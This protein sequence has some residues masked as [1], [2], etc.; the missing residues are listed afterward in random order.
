[1]AKRL[2]VVSEMDY[3]LLQSFKKDG[4]TTKV[5]ELE[6]KKLSILDPKNKVPDDVRAILYNDASRRLQKQAKIDENTP[7]YVTPF[8]PEASLQHLPINYVAK[9]DGDMVAA[10]QSTG[11]KTESLNASSTAPVS[12]KTPTT[13]NPSKTTAMPERQKLLQSVTNKKAPEIL[14]LLESSGVTWNDK[15]EVLI[16]KKRV[17]GSNVK[18]ILSSLCNGK[19]LHETPG[20]HEVSSVLMKQEIPYKLIN[21]TTQELLRGDKFT[22][23]LSSL[24]YVKTHRHTSPGKRGTYAA[25]NRKLWEKY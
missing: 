25:V 16:D 2:R 4:K 20:I 18:H 17:P 24:Q 1:M 23:K 7:L 19:S 13:L 21:R 3:N 22:P 6:D 9:Q 14:Q 5:E 8:K 15:F 11:I 12:S 10:M